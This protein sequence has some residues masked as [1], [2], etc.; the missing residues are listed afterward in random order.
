MSGIEAVEQIFEIISGYQV[1]QQ[2]P[3]SF[4]FVGDFDFYEAL[5]KAR[6]DNDPMK[7]DRLISNMVFNFC[8]TKSNELLIYRGN[9]IPYRILLASESIGR[10]LLDN[11][12]CWAPRIPKA[13]FHPLVFCST[14]L[15]G[16]TL[17]EFIGA[18]QNGRKAT[19]HEV[20]LPF[21]G[22]EAITLIPSFEVDDN[23]FVY[24]YREILPV[25]RAKLNKLPLWEAISPFR[26][27][28][29]C[30]IQAIGYPKETTDRGFEV[31]NF[32]G[33]DIVFYHTDSPPKITEFLD[34]ALQGA[35]SLRTIY[36]L[37][38]EYFDLSPK[39]L[40]DL[41]LKRNDSNIRVELSVIG[42]FSFSYDFNAF[43][44]VL[45]DADPRIKGAITD[46]FYHILVEE[47]FA[48]KGWQKSNRGD[49]SLEYRIPRW[50]FPERFIKEFG[51]TNFYQELFHLK[52]V[53]I[54]IT[55]K[56]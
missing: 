3:F 8:P 42:A 27:I 55:F 46:S 30:N 23:Q 24:D 37:E 19:A 18:I 9:R 5:E 29:G 14:A 28:R 25:S 43:K 6:E 54:A 38:E 45:I 10:R 44:F 13:A 4:E 21:C 50:D 1:Q 20:F 12:V 52:T 39:E 32:F 16:A 41:L 17:L 7:I 34:K 33:E 53:S 26:E 22:S 31:L 2:T 35:Y 40:V 47:F 51:D 48:L 11:N 49:T 15:G 36:N 56:I